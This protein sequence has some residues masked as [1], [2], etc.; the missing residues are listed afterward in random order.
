MSE[1]IEITK[2]KYYRSKEK[3]VYGV[4]I[5]DA[6][7][8]VTSN[9]NGIRSCC[10]Y[11]Q[12][13]Q[14][15]LKRCYSKVYLM[16]RPTYSDCSVCDEWLTFSIFKEW[17]IKQDW[18][19]NHLDKDILHAGNKEYSP[20]ACVFVTSR[21]NGLIHTNK[22]SRGK[23]KIG[24]SYCESRNKY[25][26][27]YNDNG[28]TVNLGRFDTELEAHQVYV[29]FKTDLIRNIANEQTEP[30]KSALILFASKLRSN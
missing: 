20:S 24:V 3:S 16:D 6:E 7:Y 18:Q 26:S 29:L 23:Y 25:Q 13:W 15:M 8:Y 28:K 4:G 30:L 19:N 21:I 12:R 14:N 27:G 11:F 10:P 2:V 5:N 17:M 9:I 22:K 1:F